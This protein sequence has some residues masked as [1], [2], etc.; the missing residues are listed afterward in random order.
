MKFNRQR[1]RRPAERGEAPPGPRRTPTHH[2]HGLGDVESDNPFDQL[3]A[4]TTTEAIN[5]RPS[6]RPSAHGWGGNPFGPFADPRDVAQ[7]KAVAKERNQTD[8]VVDSDFLSST[9]VRGL[10]DWSTVFSK[11]TRGFVWGTVVIECNAVASPTAQTTMD[12]TNHVEARIIGYIGGS[13][14]IL[15]VRAVANRQDKSEELSAGSISHRFEMGDV[16]DRLEIQIRARQGGSAET[17]QN[18]DET[19]QIAVATRFHR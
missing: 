2:V 6:D 13:A 14:R 19:L 4:L 10:G 17:A 1:P 9:D 5:E 11:D 7:R 15:A 16:P 8:D 3:G 18:S 12:K